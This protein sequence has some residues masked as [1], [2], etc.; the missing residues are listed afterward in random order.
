METF[1]I[2]GSEFICS[3]NAFCSL[4]HV[5]HCFAVILVCYLVIDICLMVNN[6]YFEPISSGVELTIISGGVKTKDDA[7]ASG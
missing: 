1:I 4:N 7:R 5:P 2:E 6:I 3:E